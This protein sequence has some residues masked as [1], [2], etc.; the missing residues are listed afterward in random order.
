MSWDDV[1]MI[2][3][4]VCWGLNTVIWELNI[5][6]KCY[7]VLV[8]INSWTYDYFRIRSCKRVVYGRIN[9]WWIRCR[10]ID[11]WTCDWDFRIQSWKRV[12]YGRTHWW[13]VRCR[14]IVYLVRLVGCF[15]S[16]VSALCMFGWL[17]FTHLHNDLD[18]FSDH[19]CDHV[20]KPLS[21]LS[22]LSAIC[23]RNLPGK[24]INSSIGHCY[25]VAVQDIM[26]HGYFAVLYKY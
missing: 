26:Y 22:D 2:W 8:V 15:L 1:A 24:T 12:V 11:S 10:N 25:L 21:L 4:S 3:L 5:E 18:D 6:G 20:V 14:N 13:W 23:C 7:F 9:C 17:C 16:I 19:L